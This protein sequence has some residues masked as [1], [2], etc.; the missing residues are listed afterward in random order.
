MSHH[1]LSTEAVA[2]YV[3]C[4]HS[5]WG[6][7]VV[8]IHISLKISVSIFPVLTPPVYVSGNCLLV[9]LLLVPI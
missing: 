9:C 1:S 8:L 3:D 2:Q 4:L 5:D 6:E 7:S